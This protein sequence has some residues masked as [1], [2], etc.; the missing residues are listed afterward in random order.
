MTQ[1]REIVLV[2]AV[3]D[4][5]K[6]ARGYTFKSKDGR[7][8]PQLRCPWLASDSN[9][10]KLFGVLDVTKAEDPE[11]I[12]PLRHPHCILH[13]KPEERPKV[14]PKCGHSGKPHHCEECNPKPQPPYAPGTRYGL[15]RRENLGGRT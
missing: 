7:L 5:D 9:R 10:C 12:E 2:I 6:C 13:E 8:H 14:C 3:S 1:Q 4:K 11:H 15:A